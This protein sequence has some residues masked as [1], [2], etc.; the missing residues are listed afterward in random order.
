VLSDLTVNI[1]LCMLIKEFNPVM[2]ESSLTSSCN[3]RPKA[4]LDDIPVVRIKAAFTCTT[5]KGAM[6]VVTSLKISK[7]E[8]SV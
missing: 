8:K 6:A 5:T 3:G 2:E 1:L 7:R 4:V